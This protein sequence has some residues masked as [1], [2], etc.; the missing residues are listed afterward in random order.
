MECIFHEEKPVGTWKARGN[1][2]IE[3]PVTAVVTAWYDEVVHVLVVD[4][5]CVLANVVAQV[6][7]MEWV[8]PSTRLLKTIEPKS[9][10]VREAVRC[11]DEW[12]ALVAERVPSPEKLDGSITGSN[13]G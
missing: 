6:V 5:G 4:S 8:P 2:G 7:A 12:Y 9:E 1:L 3:V 11:A 13:R 10:A